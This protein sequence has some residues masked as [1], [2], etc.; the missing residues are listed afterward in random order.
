[1][2]AHT[3]AKWSKQDVVLMSSFLAYY[4]SPNILFVVIWNLPSVGEGSFGRVLQAKAEGIVPGM[5][6]RNIVAI[7]TTKGMCM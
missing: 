4:H 7:K 5:P 2:C 3:Q 6:E 1:M